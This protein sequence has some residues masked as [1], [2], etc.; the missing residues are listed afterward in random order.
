MQDEIIRIAVRV[1]PAS[2]SIARST[3]PTAERMAVVATGG[4]GRG[5]LAPGSDIDL[6]FL[7]ALQADRLGRVGRRRHSLLPLGHGA[8]GRPRDALGRRMHPPGQGGHDHPHRAARGA[9]P[10]RRPRSCST[11][12]SRASTRRSCSGTAPRIRRRQARR[13]RGAAAPRRPVALP[14]RAEREG[15]QG[16]P[17]RPAHAVLDRQI[18]LSRARAGGAG[19]ARRVRPRRI[20]AVPPL[21]GFPLG[22]ALPHAF[23]HRP[24]RGAALLRHP[25]RDRGAARLHRASR[26]AGCRALHEALFPG[27]QGR[28]RPH[29]HPLRR[30][31]GAR[32]RSPCRC[33]T[34]WSRASSRGR[35]AP[36]RESD[37]FIADNNRI[38]IADPDAFRA[39]PGQPHPHLPP[40]AE[41][42]SRVPSGRDA[43][44]RRARSS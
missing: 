25:A 30:A 16:R 8:E 2:I 38:N 18:R 32:R 13:A 23:R 44:R 12:W 31:G 6:L 28:R 42:Q 4:Y 3:R 20:Q 14:G 1:A 15:R 37:D 33:S 11:S 22:G 40:R 27:R 41:A 9:L 5:L 39:R 21:R 7:L 19:R 10:V 26:H 36:L 35:A 34:A 29:R 43:R 24:R 17:A